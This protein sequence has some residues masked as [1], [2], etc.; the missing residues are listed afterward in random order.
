MSLRR[1]LLLVALAML[2]LP[3]AGWQFVRQMEVLLREG[4]EQTL[5]ASGKALARS[6]AA[7]NAELPQP[8]SALYV[9]ELEAPLQIDGY[10]DDWLELRGFSQNLGP[11]QDAQKLKMTLAADA[12]WLYC[13]IEVRDSTRRR[14]DARDAQSQA[15]DRVEL[16]LLRGSAQRSYV[17][18]SAAPGS[19]DAPARGGDG[20]GLP[21]TLG[22]EWQEEAAGY[23]V[24]FRL[25]AAQRPE[26]IALRLVDAGGG[27][28][29]TVASET[30]PLLGYSERLAGELAQFAPEATRARLV[31]GEGWLLAESGE[32]KAESPRPA[33]EPSA[34]A[35][36]SY[37][38]LIAPALQGTATLA[39]RRARLDAVE[40]WQALSGVPSASW[41]AGTRQSDVVLM[42]ALPLQIRGET[43]G[44]LVLEQVN[45][46]LPLLTDAALQ[47]LA[48]ISVAALL[49]AGGVLFVFAT[50]LSVRIRRLRDGAERALAAD[51]R[52]QGRV[53]LTDTRDELG[54]LARSF[55]HLLDAVG[56][57]TDYLRT[58]AS[59]LSHEL[60]TPL[61]IVKSSLDNLE[62]HPISAE[63]R[64]YVVRARDGTDRLT[65]IVRAMSESS[66]MERA[67]ASADA[68]DFDLA[69]VVR[70]C[71]EAYR[72]LAAPRRIDC[73][74]PTQPVPMH[75]A[76]ELIA[77]ALDKLF[78]NAR[79][80]TPESGWIRIS[81]ESGADGILLRV[82]NQGPELPA[83]MQGR[84]FDSLV[85]L[86][87]GASRG[88]APH[89][90]LGLYVVRLVAE[91]HGG[92]AAANNLPGGGGVEFV[93][94][95]R[96]MAREQ[97]LG[98]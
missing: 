67:I 43:R 21:L 73:E 2:A 82:A 83:T 37:R 7:I 71:A 89:L 22:G 1:K 97:R 49:L 61:A 29:V 51:G 88:E 40:L 55:Q 23:K 87:E 63:A 84:L 15:A 14:A 34:L 58:L 45:T 78:D 39:Q 79:S 52:I 86:R 95:L 33:Q 74:V 41:R 11:P 92:S 77:Q 93:L 54:D 35:R 85:S 19:F 53:P 59:K 66:R 62:H 60:H 69:D 16:T 65:H 64:A 36:W 47:R 31:S 94:R 76:P 26:K 44:A 6:L 9:H 3:W 5:I 57:Y 96:G 27:S 38:W 28:E 91:R 68:E 56:A 12:D 25:P 13:L 50:W 90:G 81:L 42:A 10:A 32:L 20:S 18:A 24:E 17:I 75:G 4:Q 8:G 46:A 70:G 72:P 48:L 30:L 80:F 98:R